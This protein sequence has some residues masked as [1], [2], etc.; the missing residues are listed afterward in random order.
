MT[1]EQPVPH[2]ET[3]MN[4]A[5]AM[6]AAGAYAS[7]GTIDSTAAYPLFVMDGLLEALEWAND[8]VASDE[9]ACL[10]L[11][12][13]RW[14]R[15]S[16]GQ[17]PTGAPEPLGRWIDHRIG[18]L[19]VRPGDEALVRMLDTVDMP[20]RQHPHRTGTRSD[21]ALVGALVPGML[22]HVSDGTR[23]QLAVD[24]AA[25]TGTAADFDAAAQLG[26]AL[27]ELLTADDPTAVLQSLAGT[28]VETSTAASSS[29]EA[30]DDATRRVSAA[31]AAAA[32]ASHL[33]P[34]QLPE[35]AEHLTAALIGAARGTQA[36]GALWGGSPITEVVD[37]AAGRW[38]RLVLPR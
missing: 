22:P 27:F 9:A 33:D 8:G 28:A 3:F 37:E 10:W 14:Y 20:T 34:T 4:R 7:S 36:L 2:P 29:E 23:R 1:S 17:F 25:L 19:D 26:P 5:A 16:T 21:L 32:E 31:A 6:L 13:L 24:A 38:R 18:T 11:A 12:T 35:G 15:A 30:G